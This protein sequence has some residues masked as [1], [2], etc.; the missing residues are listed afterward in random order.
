MAYL[1]AV[2]PLR[3]VQVANPDWRLA[4][5]ILGFG[6][7]GAV[8]ALLFRTGG[9][10]AVRQFAYPVLFLLT[11]LPWP[12][13]AETGFN[14]VAVPAVARATAEI[15]WLFGMP[16]VDTG[17]SILTSAGPVAVTDDCGG[18]RSFQLAVM[19]S[20]F[21]GGVFGHRGWRWVGLVAAGIGCAVFLNLARIL[22]L[23][24]VA[25]A[26]GDLS[27]VP[28]AH[29]IS[30]QVAQ[31][32]LVALLPAVAW[33]MR[34]QTRQP[35]PQPPPAPAGPDEAP[36]P[37]RK[38]LSP[39]LVAGA[40]AWLLVAEAGVEFWFLSRE[41]PGA[42]SGQWSIGIRAAQ[43]GSESLPIPAEVRRNY[44]FT[45]ARHFG[46]KDGRGA[47]WTLTWLGFGPGD[48]SACTHNVHRPEICLPAVDYVLEGRFQDLVV[49]GE[50]R[51]VTFRHQLYRKGPAIIHL[52][53]ATVHETGAPLPES[54]SEALS[55]ADWTYAG[56]LRAAWH[57][58]RSSRA[59]I[60]HLSVEYPYDPAECRRLATEILRAALSGE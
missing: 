14:R 51:T 2:L 37:A 6:A 25:S 55:P 40:A 11:A 52:F 1:A 60:L 45:D 26:T 18:I 47:P 3:C 9:M 53:F 23:V 20:V 21:L 13:N 28:R 49:S 38:P 7:A 59:E 30:G 33:M 58:V 44:R 46:W 56:R 4:D 34:P 32:A 41:S 12:M 17:R 31:V 54:A 19:A 48:L 50:G 27:L 43:P 24:L 35:Q 8:L 16:A 29:D 22:S 10:R 57:G 5:W 42:A 36:P 39:W 15:L